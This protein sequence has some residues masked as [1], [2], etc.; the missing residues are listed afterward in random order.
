MNG[1]KIIFFDFFLSRF[2]TVCAALEAVTFE[3]IGECAALLAL[4]E[5]AAAVAVAEAAVLSCEF[6]EDLRDMSD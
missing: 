3:G 2:C 1:V 6:C 4:A 5:D